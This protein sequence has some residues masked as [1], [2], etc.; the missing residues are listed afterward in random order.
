MA[1]PEPA[2]LDEADLMRYVAERGLDA[3]LIR[4]GVPTPTVAAA[5][6]AVGAGVEAIVKSLLFLAD[7]RPT[8]VVAAGE[9]RI[10]QVALASELGVSR[11]RLRFASADRALA[12]AGF[13]VGGM[14][15]FGHREPLPTLIDRDSVPMSGT[16]Y[17]GGG[18]RRS[19]L[20]LDAAVLIDQLGGRRVALS[21]T[22]PPDGVGTQGENR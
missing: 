5:A 22:A 18:S 6:A 3:E 19:L 11:R 7:G 9:G 15:P 4:P 10:S 16:L 17:V 13:P 12:I 14:P 8:L 20:R 2:P 21:E 1:E